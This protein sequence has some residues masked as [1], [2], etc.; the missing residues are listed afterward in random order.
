MRWHRANLRACVPLRDLSR[1]DLHYPGS[2][3]RFASS[4][5]RLCS[6]KKAICDK[7]V[8]ESL[9]AILDDAQ[10]AVAALLQARFKRRDQMF[11][12]AGLELCSEANSPL[13]LAS[14]RIP[15]LTRICDVIRRLSF[16]RVR[17]E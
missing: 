7:P 16:R 17:L 4:S 1:N 11:R 15:H 8:P 9:R 13:C 5:L 6:T 10:E 3:S 12:C 2:T 14:S